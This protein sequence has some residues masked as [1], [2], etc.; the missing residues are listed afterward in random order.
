[1]PLSTKRELDLG[2]VVA[3]ALGSHLLVML[4]SLARP[5]VIT[6]T[7]IV[8]PQVGWG[9]DALACGRAGGAT[10]VGLGGCRGSHQMCRGAKDIS[11]E[12]CLF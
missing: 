6:K 10:G 12:G 11:R 8:C 3:D 2:R 4:M 1:V 9:E 5:H 7:E